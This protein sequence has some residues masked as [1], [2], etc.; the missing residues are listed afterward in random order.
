MKTIDLIYELLQHVSQQSNGVFS[1]INF[2]KEARLFDS[3]IDLSAHIRIAPYQSPQYEAFLFIE[4]LDRFISPHDLRSKLDGVM[5]QLKALEERAKASGSRVYGVFATSGLSAQGKDIIKGSGF[6]HLDT[7]TNEV[8]LSLP[9]F[10]YSEALIP[11]KS[12]G[13]SISLED[14]IRGRNN[15]RTK[16][17]IALKELRKKTT[18]YIWTLKT[19]SELSGISPAAAHKL[20]FRLLDM[21]IIVPS[22]STKLMTRFT[23]TKEGKKTL[24]HLK[25]P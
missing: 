4:I 12:E 11:A 16:A 7:S 2:S 10:Y 18:D 23:L 21:G 13:S 19:L 17:S 25:L 6:L 14:V 9:G 24:E 1:V 8:Y 5:K 15:K 20:K 22:K 3:V